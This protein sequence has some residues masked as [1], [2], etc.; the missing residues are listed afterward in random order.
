[1]DYYKFFLKSSS[2][3][4]I[5]PLAVACTGMCT[6]VHLLGLS[7]Q[8]GRRQCG[9]NGECD[10]EDRTYPPLSTLNQIK[11]KLL[12]DITEDIYLLNVGICKE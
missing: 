7:V 10:M 12:S 4:L 11:L 2:L 3:V 1:M 5:S 6:H 8:V 9:E